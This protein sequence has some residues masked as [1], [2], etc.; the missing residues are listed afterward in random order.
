MKDN[1]P[2]RLVLF[3]RNA[4]INANKLAKE[5]GYSSS[6]KISRML[7]SEGNPSFEFLKDLGLYYE[8]LNLDWLV[9]G[10]GSMFMFNKDIENRSQNTSS[11]ND[12]SFPN[13]L[14]E[15]IFHQGISASELARNLDLPSS[16]AI[17][18]MLREEGNPSFEFLN[19][20]GN[21]YEN[22]SMD[23]MITGR[24]KMYHKD[25]AIYN[26][27]SK[28]NNDEIHIDEYFNARLEQ[29]M[30]FEDISANAL[31]N[32]MGYDNGSRITRVLKGHGKP[33][34]DFI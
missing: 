32:K 15:F 8:T 5:L 3:L 4:H 22:L 29:F 34:I 7:R 30:S 13:R 12:T 25:D 27:Q 1:F 6:S 18:R 20:L 24:G 28:F 21:R 23:W 14:E 11:E 17:S 26:E 16:S 9:T 2:S 10:K 19:R 31:A 33:S